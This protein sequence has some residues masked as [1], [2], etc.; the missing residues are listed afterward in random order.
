VVSSPTLSAEESAMRTRWLSGS[1]VLLLLLVGGR[2]RGDEWA[3]LRHDPHRTG[4][5]SGHL[6]IASQPTVAWSRYLGGQLG[7]GQYLATDVDG[8]GTTEIV[9]VAGGRLVAKQP[10][11]VTIWES[12]LLDINT[13]LGVADLDGDT[14][15]DIVA[16]SDDHAYVLAGADGSVEWTSPLGPIMAV[17]AVRLGDLDGDHHDDLYIGECRC[18]TLHGS[19]GGVGY[20]FFGHPIGTPVQV[21]TVPAGAGGCGASYDQ[22]ADVDGDGANELILPSRSASIGIY[23]CPS[24]AAAYTIAAPASGEFYPGTSVYPMDL[25]GDHDLELIAVTNGYQT[26]N[27]GARRIAVFDYDGTSAWTELWEA[28]APVRATDELLAEH[29]SFSD[30]DG[31]GM[32][33][34]AFTIIAAGT[35]HVEVR[36]AR[37]GAMRASLAGGRIAGIADIDHDMRSE[38][39][40]IV[41][42][43]L[44]A[45]RLMP[46][47][48]LAMIW[49]HAAT[50]PLTMIDHAR[51]LHDPNATRTLAIDLNGDMALDVVTEQTDMPGI[52]GLHALATMGG[53]VSEIGHFQAPMDVTVLT[54]SF[55]SHLT[56]A[57][58]QVMAVTSDGYLITF[59]H[60]LNPTN[61]LTDPEFS[62]PGMR[63]GGYYSGP[64]GV[65]HT[66]SIVNLGTPSIVVRDS[67]PSLTRLDASMATLRTSPTLTWERSAAAWPIVFDANGDGTRDVV[68]AIGGDVVALDAATARTELWRSAGA[69]GGGLLAD[70]LPAH[71]GTNTDVYF[72]R[73]EAGAVMRGVAL[74]GHTGT[75]RWSP[76]SQP[77]QWGYQ[78][79]SAGDLDLDG[80][81]ELVTVT[82]NTLALSG[83]D[84]TLLH[85]NGSF[86]AYANPMLLDPSAIGGTA[87]GAWVHGGYFPDRMLSAALATVATRTDVTTP[88]TGSYGALVSCGGAPAVVEATF[89]ASDLYVMR[90][91]SAT[92]LAHR[93]I[94]AGDSYA[95]GA[96]PAGTPL[97]RLGNVTSVAAISATGGPAVLV[98]STDGFLYALDPCALTLI[99]SV[100][101]RYPVGEPIVGDVDGNGTDDLLVTVADGFLYGIGQAA[102][103]APMVNDVDP[104]GGSP[105]TDVDQI[106]TIDTLYAEWAPVSGATSYLVGVFTA[107]GTELRFPNYRDVGN[108]TSVTLSMLPLRQG[109]RYFVS[110][111]A[112]GPAGAGL[113]GHS[114]G[115]TVTDRL[116]PTADIN[117]TPMASWPPVGITPIVT[118]HC[119]DRV[120]LMHTHV[121]VRNADGMVVN[122]LDDR[123]A[124]GI[125]DTS[126][127]AWNGAAT[128][129]GSPSAG[130]Y[131]AHV[132]CTDATNMTAEA[133]A[134]FT[135]DPSVMGDAGP[136]DAAV[137]HDAAHVIA[138]ASSGGC[139][140]RAGASGSST[141][142][143]LV[144]IALVMARRRR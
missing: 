61:R 107:A 52:V 60:M 113:E 133:D 53:A 134:T 63:V 45:Y 73:Q 26:T 116:P 136:V 102:Y 5:S 111:R 96:V 48:G 66:P 13:L 83:V 129:G 22:I 71:H 65:G 37:T 139:G 15:A 40:V 38:L 31:D 135:L 121:E 8:D 137:T 99:W 11:N 132:T 18:C 130:T 127:H 138:P 90:P 78:S 81:D 54:V 119:M 123:A 75:V 46:G 110:V 23:R 88:N 10:T 29:D 68:M 35:P 115:V 4:A 87:I 97:G 14:H 80:N 117:V 16:A 32:I 24:A 58:T 43:M 27:G 2:A 122:V 124:A 69:T 131:H 128:A 21:F 143:M 98:G 92:P 42:G 109:G 120:A 19:T 59:D 55:G 56:D 125:T 3:T 141:L 36:D 108:M 118:A 103:P 77:L 33:E 6:A 20:S 12:P 30:F 106:D 114:N 89:Q 34:A 74:D 76:F 101:L 72:P 70:M 7:A 84:G 41:G 57:T 49:S 140:C 67:R 79:W 1:I 9:F 47:A 28:T 44:N 51:L 50:T 17:G 85:D 91:S 95:A 105:T 64:A 94:A 93:V 39:L 126:T 25:D 86:V 112:L 144:A 104:I 62:L 82:N 142:A 100:N